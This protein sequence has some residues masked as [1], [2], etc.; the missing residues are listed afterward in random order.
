MNSFDIYTGESLPEA[1]L[2]FSYYKHGEHINNTEIL[3]TRQDNHRFYSLLLVN[4]LSDSLIIIS[5]RITKDITEHKKLEGLKKK[6]IET[7]T[8]KR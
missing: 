7:I 1:K 4:P 8:R 2:I 6:M 3:F 5:R